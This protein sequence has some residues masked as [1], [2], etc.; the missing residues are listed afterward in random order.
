M[1][2]KDTVST[3]EEVNQNNN[4][5]VESSID[6]VSNETNNYILNQPISSNEDTTLDD[7]SL[8]TED[9]NVLA[10][11]DAKKIM[12]YAGRKK[13]KVRK[14]KNEI[15]KSM[16]KKLEKLTPMVI[17]YNGPD[18]V[19]ND[20]KV[21]YKY[22]AKAPNGR[23]V[24]EYTEAFS[25][26]E[27]HSYLLSEG[28]EVYS[29]ETS[30][31]IGMAHSKDVITNTKMKTKDLVFFLTQLSTY[32]KA[33]IPL[34]DAMRV[35]V[36]QY[37]KP[38]YQ[39]ILQNIVH[40]LVNGDAFSVALEKSGK[41][42]PKLLINMVKVSE[43]TGDLP[44]TLDEMAEYYDEIETTRKQMITAMMYPTM[45][46]I[47]AIAVIIFVLVW[48][49][50][51][52]VEIYESMDPD[53]I[54]GFTKMIIA[55]S[56]F[57]RDFGLW[58]LLFIALFIIVYRILYVHVR[59]IRETTQWVM[60]HIPVISNVIIYNEVTMF[61]KTFASLLKY[62]V[63]ITDSME[64]LMKVTNNEIY[65]ALIYDTIENLSRGE[66]ISYAFKDHWAFP[67]PAYTMLITGEKTGQLP[68]MMDKV[69]AYYQEQHK[70]SV[71]R[72]KTFIEPVLIIFLT[73]NVGIIILAIVLPM[74]GMYDMVM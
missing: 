35:L 30:K 6:E 70:Q 52:F 22:V 31:W 24:T 49:I 20:V 28:Y 18:G 68:E 47:F 42:F 40:N 13:P 39:K 73:V 33:G 53:K 60:M 41:A 65:K 32:I 74:F 44:G 51:Q 21:I 7:H 63:F 36:E 55:F 37:K 72:I 48:V 57:L 27:V 34:A 23:L 38:V 46:F 19:K 54:P 67:L 61:T 5:S 9:T 64:I 66:R 8:Y 62:N 10:D 1:D 59:S 12:E 2:Q 50:P 29:I 14:A 69:A 58:I 45:V 15:P 16:Q 11:G 71:T 56:D 43:M 26:A 4:H 25:V 3:N 17:D